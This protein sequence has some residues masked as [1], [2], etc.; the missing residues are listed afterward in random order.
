MPL[1]AGDAGL[2]ALRHPSRTTAVVIAL[3]PVALAP[4]YG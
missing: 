4:A 3:T 2:A 1:L